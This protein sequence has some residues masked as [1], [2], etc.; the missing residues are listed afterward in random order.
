MPLSKPTLESQILAAF[1][2]LTTPAASMEISQ[3]ELAKD[4][5][6]AINAFVKSAKIKPI[7]VPAGQAVATTG[8]PSAQAGA[9]VAPVQSNPLDRCLE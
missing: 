1:K 2:K 5:A 4:L 9:T 8:S 7:T 3:R 6:N